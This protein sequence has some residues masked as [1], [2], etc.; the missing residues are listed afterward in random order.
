MQAP[1]GFVKF[2]F[3]QYENLISVCGG[4][5]C[6]FDGEFSKLYI[7]NIYI[8]IIF[9]LAVVVLLVDTQRVSCAENII[10][11]GSENQTAKVLPLTLG[12]QTN[13]VLF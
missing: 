9:V 2:N 1:T 13:F 4:F 8:D 11:K 10:R 5:V 12:E 7:S 3:D 6:E